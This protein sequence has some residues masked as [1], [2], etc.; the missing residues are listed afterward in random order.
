MVLGSRAIATTALTLAL[1]GCGDSDPAADAEGADAAAD[2]S[3]AVADARDGTTLASDTREEWPPDTR[4]V[5][6]SDGADAPVPAD[7]ATVD[8]SDLDTTTVDISDLDATTVDTTGLDT[9]TLDTTNPDTT[10]A[11]TLAPDTLAPDTTIL[12]TATPD[13]ASPDTASVDTATPDTATPL[14]TGSLVVTA[15]C[16][17]PGCVGVPGAWVIRV[18]DCATGAPVGGAT[19]TPHTF[20]GLMVPSSHYVGEFPMGPYCVASHFDLDGV[21]GLSAGDAV[22]SDG[23]AVHGTVEA[24]SVSVWVLTLEVPP[25]P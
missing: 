4:D 3:D 9:A 21:P 19:L 10:T 25:L 16:G 17:S 24:L 15:S 2:V 18:L 7:T 23:A 1:L 20:A 8:T 22:A 11:D 14:P 12:D 6:D 13:T 5:A